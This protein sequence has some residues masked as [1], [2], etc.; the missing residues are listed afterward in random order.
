M[1]ERCI[2]AFQRA[3][4]NRAIEH[5]DTLRSNAL[6]SGGTDQRGMA[7]LR[8]ALHELSTEVRQRVDEQVTTDLLT[9]PR[10]AL[11]QLPQWERGPLDSTR[12]HPPWRATR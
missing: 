5:A 11:E 3:L 10:G 12:E 9:L 1:R 7:R 4:V 2:A 6:L 8:I